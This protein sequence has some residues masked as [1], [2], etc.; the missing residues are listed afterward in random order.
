MAKQPTLAGSMRMFVVA[1]AT[2]V[3]TGVPAAGQ[4]PADV[5]F[6]ES[7]V[8]P[9][10]VAHCYDC[11]GPDT[12]WA[13]LRVDSREGL[14]T[15]GDSG[16]ALDPGDPAHSLLVRAVKRGEELQ[17]P[18]DDPLSDEQISILEEW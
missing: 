16:A 1:L 9:L 5:A 8:R 17:M 11:H 18:P 2:A 3:G 13:E 7:H 14:L 12:Q 6:F 10:L 4:S 15:G